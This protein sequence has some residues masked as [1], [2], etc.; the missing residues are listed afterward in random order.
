M[1]GQERRDDLRVRGRGERD[2]VLAQLG[3]EL[4]RVD[5]VAVVG[6]RQRTTVVA[7][8]R[9]GVLP[10][11]RAGGGVADVADGQI[12]DQRAELVLV[13]HL[14]HQALVA[15]RHDLPTERCRG[16]AGRLLAAMLQ[17]E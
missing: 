2:V 15:D 5:Q 4:D 13:E 11:R 12:T 10:L 3:V 8:D 17:C 16:D 7:D 1:G 14:R 6:E 9:L